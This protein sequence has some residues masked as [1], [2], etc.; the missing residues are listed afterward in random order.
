MHKNYPIL[1]AFDL[2]LFDGAAGGA[3]A[4]GAASGGAAGAG[5]AQGGASALPKAGS[6][7]SGSSRQSKTGD[8]STG[9]QGDASAAAA[10]NGSDAG[11]TG[12]GNAKTLEERRRAYREMM[13]GEFKDLYTEDTQRIINRRFKDY[14]GLEDSLSAQ[15][16]IMD[17][18]A[19]RF[20]IEDGDAGKLL[21]A[22]ENDN[23]FWEDAAEKAGYTVEQFKAMKKLERE[24]KEFKR[25]EQQKQ[26]QEAYRQ[27]MAAWMNEAEQVRER[28]PAFDLNAEVKN[29]QFMTLLKNKF[30]MEQAYEAVHTKEIAAAEAQRA[31]ELAGQQMQANIRARGSR[32]SENGMSHQSA[33]MTKTDVHALSKADRAEYARRALRGEKNLKF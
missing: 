20:N 17:M 23:T 2:Q 7:Q 6:Q 30:S 33:V 15:K 21:Q 16:P 19:Q 18:L 28:Y 31:A 29:P 22:L 25:I 9:K 27:Q 32:P 11:N 5:A 1:F 3:A 8:L 14:K 12:E 26:S 13:D 24:N 10:K 4:G